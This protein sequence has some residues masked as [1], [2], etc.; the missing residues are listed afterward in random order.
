MNEIAPVSSS[1]DTM[2]VFLDR[3]LRDPTIEIARLEQIIAL[4][5]RVSA[6]EAKR[7]YA[8]AMNAVQREMPQVSKDR[9]NP[10]TRSRYATYEEIDDAIRPIYTRQGF[11]IAFETETRGERTSV[12]CMVSH[13]GGH[14]EGK[15]Q[16]ESGPD[17]AGSKGTANKVEVQ[18]VGSIVSYL[19]RYTLQA[20]FA[21]A[22]KND[23]TDDDGEGA[24][25]PG[26]QQ[27]IQTRAP[28][29][30]DEP[31]GTKWLQNLAR[32]LEEA[33]TTDDVQTLVNDVS[34]RRTLDDQATPSLIKTTIEGY[35]T[36]AFARVGA[37]A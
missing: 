29:P 15:Y 33:K 19:K 16:L 18:G 27:Q 30:L 7:Q 1:S 20:A 23:E 37:A 22:V 34:V 10:H 11:S 17:V 35:F 6:R 36:A 28:H 13:V 3:V 9:A 2:L 26:R 5:E 8:E 25:R 32:L 12:R 21:V 14:S 31:N 4:H 24:R